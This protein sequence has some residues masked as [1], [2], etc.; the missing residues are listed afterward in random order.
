MHWVIYQCKHCCTSQFT[1][2][3]F[4][5]PTPLWVRCRVCLPTAFPVHQFT[6]CTITHRLN[7]QG[8]KNMFVYASATGHCLLHFSQDWEPISLQCCSELLI[9][10]VHKWKTFDFFFFFFREVLRCGGSELWRLACC[11]LPLLLHW[12]EAHGVPV[13]CMPVCP[14]LVTLG[15]EDEHHHAVHAFISCS[16]IHNMLIP[17]S[18]TKISCFMF[19]P[20]QSQRLPSLHGHAVHGFHFHHHVSPGLI[21]C[22]HGPNHVLW[23]IP[24]STW[25][26]SC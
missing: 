2:V 8:D 1:S 15:V 22:N 12:S 14:Q 7:L 18:I 20:K 17:E 11:R 26:L 23:F 16:W 3:V 4:W 13:V 6:R 10:T 9:A 19:R 5:C 25:N 21:P 24:C